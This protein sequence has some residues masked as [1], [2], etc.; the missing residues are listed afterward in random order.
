MLKKIKL[1]GEQRKILTL[2]M[3]NPV[4][5]KGVAGSGKSTVALYRARHLH[6]TDRG[7]FSFPSVGII[8]FSKPLAQ[9]L[10]SL[11]PHVG[12]ADG[13]NVGDGLPVSCQ[14]FHAWAWKLLAD[15]YPGFK[16]LNVV[17][18]FKRSDVVKNAVRIVGGKS[19]DVIFNQPTVFFEEE[20]SWIKGRGIRTLKDYKS[21]PRTGRGTSV[22]VIES[23]RELIWK[24]FDSYNQLLSQSN[25]IDYDDFAL[26]AEVIVNKGTFRKP[27]TH[28]VIDEAQDL[29]KI[30]LSVLTKLVSN[31]TNSISL[32]ADAAQRIYQNGFS[33]KEIGLNVTGG[34]TVELSIDY[35]NPRGIALAATKILKN[36]KDRSDF[37]VLKGVKP[38]NETPIVKATSSDDEAHSWLVKELNRIEFGDETVVVLHR[39]NSGVNSIGQVLQHNGIEFKHFR[40]L[41]NGFPESGVVVCTMSSVKGMEFDHVF[42]MDASSDQIPMRST[43]QEADE[44]LLSAERRLFYTAMTRAVKS[45]RI[46]YVQSPCIYIEEMLA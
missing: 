5:I 2:P 21:T 38:G 24:V 15:N 7:L 42:I 22:R 12:D 29:T 36:E 37:T 32:I 4:Q 34:R 28:L 31:E 16:S 41:G 20:I 23:T 27:F 19:S 13:A 6:D 8:T 10:R 43:G 40:E 30:Q 26:M 25:S 33:W 18:G 35:R 1:S 45:L 11:L 9:Y 46:N 17:S 3:K 14:T 39:R 44:E